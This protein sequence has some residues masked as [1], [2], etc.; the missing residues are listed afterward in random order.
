LAESRWRLDD[1]AAADFPGDVMT[2]RSSNLR[3]QLRPVLECR[4][5]VAGLFILATGCAQVMPPPEVLRAVAANPELTLHLVDDG[6][7]RLFEV[8]HSTFGRK[9]EFRELDGPEAGPPSRPTFVVPWK[10]AAVRWM[11]PLNLVVEPKFYERSILRANY[12]LKHPWS[13]EEWVLAARGRS[14]S[15]GEVSLPLTE[16]EAP[17]LYFRD[18]DREIG[19]LNCDEASRRVLF[20][21][22][23]GQ[24]VEIE[25]VGAFAWDREPGLLQHFFAPFPEAG[26]F[27]IRIDERET[28]RFLVRGVDGANRSLRLAIRAD[29]DVQLRDRSLW[30]FFAFDRMQDFVRGTA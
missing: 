9:M 15:A 11:H 12:R 3:S 25:Q 18:G 20:G 14:H 2:P 29:L 21:Q 28:A 22:L 7:W 26:E 17:V 13:G 1:P 19:R 8:R 4:G 16:D 24:E 23:D 5:L 6:N 30:L 27:V 10:G